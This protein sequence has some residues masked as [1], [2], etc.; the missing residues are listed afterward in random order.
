MKKKLLSTLIGAV[1]MQAA[2]A[3][4]AVDTDRSV[5]G[6]NDELVARLRF[7]A[8]DQGDLYVA[9]KIQ[10]RLLF[11]GE[12][13]QFHPEPVPYKR[14][15]FFD[16]GQTETIMRFP[17]VVIPPGRYILYSAI[18]DTG[19]DVYDFS[20]WHGPLA[21]QLFIVNEPSEQSRDFDGDGWPDDDSDHDG[22]SEADHNFDGW[23]DDDA[24][25]NG[26]PDAEETGGND[27]SQGSNDHSGHDHGEDDGGNAGTGG[28]TSQ[29]AALYSQHCAG[30]HGADPANGSNKIRNGADP[31]RISWAISNNRGGMSFLA[32]QLS[33][34]DIQ[35]I[36]AYIASR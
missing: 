32:G 27:D 28:N 15:G 31:G 17:G 34:A 9:A 22:F 10:G 26:V 14:D 24:D 33:D 36:A 1:L 30:C 21:K 35:A 2:W 3:D 12:D 7:P 16:Q 29:G 23:R 20:R 13:G 11:F 4:V 6:Q 5:V 19:A 25:H 18:T 8:Q